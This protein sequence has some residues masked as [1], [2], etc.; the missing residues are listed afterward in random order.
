MIYI[1]DDRL[2]R[3]EVNKEKLNKFSNV[4][5]FETIKTNPGKSIE[6]S[7]IESMRDNPVCIIFHKSYIFDDS[8]L[9][10]EIVREIFNSYD[11]P[12]VIFSGGIEKNNKGE[13]EVNMNAEL[14]YDNLPFFLE[15]YVNNGNINLDILVW[16]K[17]YKLNALLILQNKLAEEF[18][19]AKDPKE[20]VN[21]LEEVRRRIASICK[22]IHKV[23][24]DTILNS[25]D[26]Y[27]QL[28]WGQLDDII[29]NT[30]SQ[31]K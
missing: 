7:L 2:Q 27:P 6:E 21:T 18:F 4:L 26:K 13:R 31:Y 12:V 1:F 15:D 19:I 8:I 10:Y 11:V 25:I 22:P 23:I 28:T 29:T 3:R 9:S 14:M 30:I 5:S 24:G 20:E 17:R 16:G